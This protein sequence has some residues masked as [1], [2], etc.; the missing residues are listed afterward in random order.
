PSRPAATSPS[1]PTTRP[2]EPSAPGRSSTA[3]RPFVPSNPAPEEQPSSAPSTPSPFVSRR[4]LRESASQTPPPPGA[5]VRQTAVRPPSS[6]AVRGLN[7]QGGLGEVRP[8]TGPAIPEGHFAQVRP[9]SASPDSSAS[10][11]A[12]GPGSTQAP[13]KAGPLPVRTSGPSAA[14]PAAPA[15]HVPSAGDPTEVLSGPVPAEPR[16]PVSTVAP[17]VPVPPIARPEN[18]PPAAPQPGMPAQVAPFVPARPDEPAPAQS[19]PAQAAPA[20]WNGGTYAAPR[21]GQPP[22]GQ[23]GQAPSPESGWTPAVGGAVRGPV[24]PGTLPPGVIAPVSAP[25]PPGTFV[26]T[27]SVPI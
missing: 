11:P 26:P 14:S 27:G 9:A 15:P 21:P 19:A 3:A 25:P 6:G 12:N 7:P 4:E 1:R 16:R 8:T 13:A 5:P 23:R 2:A 10:G 18:A 24:E 20:A 22:F 17:G